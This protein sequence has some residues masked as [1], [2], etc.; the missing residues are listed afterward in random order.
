MNL[1]STSHWRVSSSR[2]LLTLSGTAPSFASDTDGDGLSDA[3]EFPSTDDA[4][5]YPIEMD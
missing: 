4:A 1:H 5:F 3:S 2:L